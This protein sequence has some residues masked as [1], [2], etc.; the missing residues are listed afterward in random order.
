MLKN[1]N[2]VNWAIKSIGFNNQSIK[3]IEGIRARDV[4]KDWH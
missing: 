4:I 2:L 1:M 3:E